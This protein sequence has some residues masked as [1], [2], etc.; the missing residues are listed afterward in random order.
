LNRNTHGL[1]GG[2]QM[3]LAQI[4]VVAIT[5]GLN[6]LDGFD[7]L[8]ISYASPGIAREWGIDRGALGYVL[9]MEMLGMSIGSIL[10]GAIADRIGRRQILLVSLIVMTAGM[11]LASTA[12]NTLQL[13][14][15]R[16]LTGIGIGGVLATT[17]ALA[18]EFSSESRR[19]LSVSLMAIGYPLGAVAGGLIVAHLLRQ[20]TWHSI[21]LVGA[22]F[23]AA[24]IPLVLLWVPESISWLYHRRPPAALDRINRSLARLGRP[25]LQALPSLERDIAH[26]SVFELFRGG[27]ATRTVLATLTYFLHITT[28]YFILKWVPTIVVSMGFSPSAAAGVLVWANIGGASG[29]ALLGLLTLRWTLKYLTA[30]FLVISTACVAVFGHGQTTLAGLS[31]ICALTGFFTN[32][33]VVGIYGVLARTF[34]DRLRAGGTGFAIGIGRGGAVLAPIIAGLLFR[35]GYGLQF[36]SIAMSAGSLV[37]ALCLTSLRLEGRRTA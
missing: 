3:S 35:A 29:G 37:A 34:P 2:S 25:P 17:N 7:V 19:D 24:F 21:F 12:A 16:V 32:G 27:L 30:T 13:C 18:S 33:G 8:S 20:H 31:M 36:I 10:L 15:W 4:V 11:T 22:V 1:L 23:T 5:V 9:S 28:F 14:S 6:A 26:P